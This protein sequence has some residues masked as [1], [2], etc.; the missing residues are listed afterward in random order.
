MVAHIVVR[1]A[2]GAVKLNMGCGQNRLAGYVNVDIAPECGPDVVFDLERTPWPWP[3]GAAQEVRFVHAL[4]HMGGDAKVFLA[5]MRELY[6]ICAPGAEVTIHVPHPR[7][8]NFVSDPTHVRP[9][10]PQTLTLFDWRQNQVWKEKGAA[11]TPL[12]L[13]L[14]VDFVTEEAQVVLAEPYRSRFGRGELS[15]EAL[16][17]AVRSL[18]NV[19]EEFRMRLRVRKPLGGLA[20]AGSEG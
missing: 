16:G 8:D 12:G 5:M 20:P 17:E 13:Y 3:D 4:E 19:V 7:H 10:T 14:G 1:S 2:G 15:R 18:N 11:N 6:R 9:I